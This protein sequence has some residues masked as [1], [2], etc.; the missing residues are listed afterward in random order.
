MPFLVSYFGLKIKLLWA[1]HL[2]HQTVC[3][4]HVQGILLFTLQT[5]KSWNTLSS[6]TTMAG[7]PPPNVSAGEYGD[8]EGLLPPQHIFYAKQTK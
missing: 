4:Y 7:M 1:T 6:L 5:G 3:L 2:A 8:M